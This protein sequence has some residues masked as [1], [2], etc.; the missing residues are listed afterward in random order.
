ME[1][2]NEFH[3]A[4]AGLLSFDPI[5][6]LRDVLKRWLVVLLAALAVGVGTYISADMN[7]QPVYQTK[8]TFVVT[9]RGSSTTVYSN[10]SSTSNL[11]GLFTEL[12]NSSLMRKTIVQEMG[13][14]SFGGTIDT[15]VVPNTNLIT[16]TVS[17]T[18]PRMAFLASRAIIEHHE[19]LTYQVVGDIGLE[20][21]QNPTV[22]TTPKNY[23]DAFTQMKKAALIAGAAAAALLAVLSY[24]QDTVRSAKEAREKLECDYLGEIPHENKYKTLISSLRRKKGSILITNPVTGFHFVENI[25][26]L[27]RR[28]EQR[29]G[30]GKVLMV[31]SLLENE[32]KS[33]VAVNLALALEQKRKRVLLIDCDLRK[34]ACWKVLEQQEFTYGIRDVLQE[35]AELSD[36]FLRYQ[37]TDMYMLLAK[38][39]G[40]GAGELVTSRHMRV[41]L[42][43]ARANFDYV[44]LDLPPMSAAPEAEG[45]TALAD[46][47]L[48]VVRQN[49]AK[50]PAL[51]SA[52]SNLEGHRAKML[53]C[54]L[55]NVYETRLS[56]G[57]GYGGYSA[58]SHYGHYGNYG[59][60][61]SGGS[62]K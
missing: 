7:Y 53:G 42:D 38:N 30:G 12:L 31:T 34:P 23:N 41:L 19:D 57:Q 51:N 27:C 62:R 3:A 26:K 46:A 28:V 45:M 60:Y 9:T 14:D 35:T 44:I 21:L 25:R 52:I 11:A 59:N 22:P 2:T 17:D 24:M 39:G 47:C 16:M 18:D 48:M 10:L 36:C 37:D 13:V 55:N 6:L 43:W 33:T 1:K 8:T 20:V 61:G 29:V 58:Y 32:G 5:I 50:A 40:E 15:A 54:V 4:D 56:S 49:A